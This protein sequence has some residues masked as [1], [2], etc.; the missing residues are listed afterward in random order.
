MRRPLSG[1]TFHPPAQP[2]AASVAHSHSMMSGATHAHSHS[3]PMALSH[4]PSAFAGP[5]TSPPVIGAAANQS[6]QK[7]RIQA[8]KFAKPSG[9]PVEKNEKT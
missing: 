7:P 6:V 8:D 4:H 1:Q 2:P 3:H 5:G 9:F